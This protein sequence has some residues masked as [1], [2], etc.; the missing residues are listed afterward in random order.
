LFQLDK[1]IFTPNL[2]AVTLEGSKQG[3]RGAA[4]NGMALEKETEEPGD[5][6]EL[7]GRDGAGRGANTL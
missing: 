3:K 2:G 1:V 4:K 5:G 6:T 7:K